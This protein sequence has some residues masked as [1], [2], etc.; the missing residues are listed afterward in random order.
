MKKLSLGLLTVLATACGSAQHASQSVAKGDSVNPA[1]LVFSEDRRPADGALTEI[2]L[3]RNTEGQYDATMRRVF[4]DMRTGQ[5]VERSEVL[6]KNLA[7][8][9]A[10]VAISCSKD[11]RP[12]DG[13]LTV[14]TISQS[15]DVYVATLRHAFYDRINGQTVDNTEVL[16]DNL[17]Q[18]R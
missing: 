15:G 9:F 1:E 6:G 17:T 12:V 10:A 11:L 2:S 18:Q 4:V 16:A 3:I 14:L 5:E 7:C 8:E 13:A